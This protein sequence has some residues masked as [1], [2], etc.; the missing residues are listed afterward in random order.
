MPEAERLVTT[1][2]GPTSEVSVVECPSCEK[3][4]AVRPGR[5]LCGRCG[6]WFTVQPAGGESP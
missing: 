6:V 1:I 5:Y 4:R 2:D 3:Q